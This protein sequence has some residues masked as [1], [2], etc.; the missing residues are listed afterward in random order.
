MEI[1]SLT[2]VFG[3]DIVSYLINSSYYFPTQSNQKP[4]IIKSLLKLT[5]ILIFTVFKIFFSLLFAAI[6]L[7]F[8]K[9]IVYLKFFIFRII[10]KLH[11]GFQIYFDF[12]SIGIE[13][14]IIN[15]QEKISLKL[16]LKSGNISL[17]SIFNFDFVINFESI[18]FDLTNTTKNKT[19]ININ[20]PEINIMKENIKK[21]I[22]KTQSHLT[23]YFSIFDINTLL[24]LANQFKSVKNENSSDSKNDI[25]DKKIDLDLDLNLDMSD[26]DF[27]IIKSNSPLLLLTITP[28]KI[29]YSM[30]QKN[31]EQ[32]IEIKFELKHLCHNSYKVINRFSTILTINNYNID[33]IVSPIHISLSSFLFKEL[34]SP[35]YN[36]S[37]HSQLEHQYK[38]IFFQNDTKLEIDLF[39]INKEKKKCYIQLNDDKPVKIKEEDYEPN[40][41]MKF[42][43]KEHSFTIKSL[44]S[45]IL[46]DKDIIVSLK[47]ENGINIV[48]FTSPYVF[49]NWLSYDIDIFLCK[50]YFLKVKSTKDKYIPCDI[51]FDLSKLIW[52]SKHDQFHID[53]LEFNSSEPVKLM[54][55]NFQIDSKPVNFYSTY[56]LSFDTTKTIC[57]INFFPYITISNFLP[58]DVKLRIENIKD[59]ELKKG[60]Y[61][62]L[63]YLKD[64][65]ENLV[66]FF[67]VW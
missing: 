40:I 30:S 17:T 26:I 29:Q 10:D 56:F 53:E 31:S 41:V 34:F 46:L 2:R 42:K 51:N 38:N 4:S 5:L 32:K 13:V 54:D 45:P 35:E 15:F 24:N 22:V 64:I 23:I 6:N 11:N 60:L 3:I 57:S 49:Q 67:Q 20:V 14:P 44:Y 58:Y 55:Y 48:H 52:V 61:Y 28:Q 33:V 25:D 16:I 62:D 18:Q 12:I 1:G 63:S 65:D 39:L 36:D 7:M 9:Y 66:F 50:N 37:Y 43:D 21:L 27:Y 47:L 19:I 59:I 8:H